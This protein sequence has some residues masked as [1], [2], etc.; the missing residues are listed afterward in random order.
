MLRS[1][2]YQI[3]VERQCICICMKGL[4]LEYYY[5]NY[6]KEC[7][8]SIRFQKKKITGEEKGKWWKSYMTGYWSGVKV[9][10][11]FKMWKGLNTNNK[12]VEVKPCEMCDY[13]DKGKWWEAC[14]DSVPSAPSSGGISVE[15]QPKT[16]A[17]NKNMCFFSTIK[18]VWYFNANLR[19]LQMLPQ[20]EYCGVRLR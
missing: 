20:I 7:D 4:M 15:L 13:T 18:Q 19:R 12:Q 14:G 10:M 2:D 11:K 17:T 8:I 3:H 5:R 6:R 9:M 16:A 1:S